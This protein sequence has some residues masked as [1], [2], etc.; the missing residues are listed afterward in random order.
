[1]LVRVLAGRET[2]LKAFQSV[3]SKVSNKQILLGLFTEST[4]RSNI[5]M[6]KER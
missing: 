6:C 3:C 1:M 2:I 5:L 4:P